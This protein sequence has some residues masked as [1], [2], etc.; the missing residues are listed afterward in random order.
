LFLA[1]HSMES[2][3]ILLAMMAEHRNYLPSLGLLLPLS[4]YLSSVRLSRPTL[5]LLLHCLAVYL[6]VLCVY[7]GAQRAQQWSGPP[8][9]F[10]L[11][12]LEHRPDSMPLH[13]GAGSTYMGFSRDPWLSREQSLHLYYRSLHH[14]RRAA[15]LEPYGITPL[16]HMMEYSL[17]HAQPVRAAWHEEMKRRLRHRGRIPSASIEAVIYMLRC[18]TRGNCSLRPDRIEELV[19]IALARPRLPYRHQLY[20]AL[21]QYYLLYY[22]DPERSYPWAQRL[23]QLP[24]GDYAGRRTLVLI[25]LTTG[26]HDLALAQVEAMRARFP[27]RRYTRE[28]S[29]LEQAVRHG[30]TASLWLF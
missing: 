17:R 7:L 16:M 5:T 22:R 10:F 24:R 11:D 4:Y 3:F 20:R 25:Y 19:E 27:L 1:G 9:A 13:M 21:A 15:E 8:L 30:T 12:E 23:L 28:F 29:D 6:V 26:R 14:L 2:S 18:R